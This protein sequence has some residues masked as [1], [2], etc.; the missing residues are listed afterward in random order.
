MPSVRAYLG[1]LF[2][3][4]GPEYLCPPKLDGMYGPEKNKLFKNLAM[5][6]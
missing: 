2:H 5:S 6:K 3:G 4:Y 1:S